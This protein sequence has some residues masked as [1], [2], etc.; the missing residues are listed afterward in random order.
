MVRSEDSS[1]A[2]PQTKV[3]SISNCELVI[4]NCKMKGIGGEVFFN[5][6]LE[7]S[8]YQFAILRPYET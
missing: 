6:Q 5:L 1:E 2:L 4:A 8:N 3:R 7:I